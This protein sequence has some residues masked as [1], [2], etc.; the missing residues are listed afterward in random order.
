MEQISDLVVFANRNRVTDVATQVRIAGTSRERRRGLLDTEEFHEGSGIW[1]LP[2]E[3]IHTFGMKFPIDSIF[4][5]KRL[6]VRSLR[7]GLRPGRI[8]FCLA[9][10]SVLELPVGTI[11]KSGTLLGDQ[12]DCRADT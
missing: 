5:D 1:I 11:E 2:C 4:L 8:A 6:R 3:A 12:L 10:H 9:A 7:K